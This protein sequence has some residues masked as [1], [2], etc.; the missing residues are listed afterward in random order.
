MSQ[1]PEQLQLLDAHYI[2]SSSPI[3]GNPPG[4]RAI[5]SNGF[6]PPVDVTVNSLL[7]VISD[8]LYGID[9]T[10]ITHN[11]RT[12]PRY[13]KFDTSF[14]DTVVYPGGVAVVGDQSANEMIEIMRVLYDID[15]S[16]G[17][18]AAPKTGYAS[19]TLT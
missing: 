10:G 14:G 13:R 17:T 16:R 5:Y 9:M 19:A 15:R 7:A 3:K 4:D 18:K 6:T 11:F 8:T 12:R 2:G 1:Y